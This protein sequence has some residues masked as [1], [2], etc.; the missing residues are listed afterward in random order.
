MDEGMP[1]HGEFCWTEIATGDLAGAL[2]F[3][4]NVFG[5]EIKESNSV[6]EGMRYEEFCA[7]GGGYPM[8]G[9]YQI[10]PEM[11]G[12]NPP[13]PHLINYIAVDDA[14]ATA[15][16]AAEIGGT[17]VTGPMDIPTVGR[18]AVIQDPTGA[19]FAIIKLMEVAHNG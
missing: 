13:P 5:W 17:V 6:D 14:D 4:R 15:A 9:I 11:F 3:Y 2:N 16:R 10:N 19:K 18:M 7:A 1:K 12:P 8:G